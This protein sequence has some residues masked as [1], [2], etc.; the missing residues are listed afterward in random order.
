MLRKSFGYWLD[1]H[2][3]LRRSWRSPLSI[4]T[5]LTR[6]VAIAYIGAALLAAAPSDAWSQTPA[7]TRAEPIAFGALSAGNRFTCGLSTDGV[8]YCWGMD[9]LGQLGIGAIVG[10]C[11]ESIYAKGA[12]ARAPVAVFGGHRFLSISAGDQH[13]CAIDSAGDAYCWGENHFDQLG[14]SDVPDRCTYE[15]SRAG[16]SMSLACSRRPLRVPIGAPVVSIATGEHFTCAVDTSGRAWCWGGS[17]TPT[18][19]PL[20]RPLVSVAAGGNQVCGLTVDKGIRCWAWK[21]VLTDG[22]SA[23]SASTNWTALTVGAGHACALDTAGR[24]YCWGNDADGALGI[25]RNGH[26]KHLDVPMTPIVGDRR[27]RSIA[28]GATQTCGIDDSGALYCWGRVAAGLSDDQ[29][30]DSNG[31]AGTNDCMTHPLLVHRNHRFRA[32]AV[33]A[34]H[35]CS[36]STSGEALCWG[37]NEAGQ[38]GDGTLRATGELT[39]VRTRGISP[40]QARILDARERITWLLARGGFGLVVIIALMLTARDW[41]ASR[42]GR[43][44]LVYWIGALMFAAVLRASNSFATSR[45]LASLGAAAAIQLLVIVLGVTLYRLSPGLR[46]WWRAG[47]RTPA[48]EVGAPAATP[49]GQR[50]ARG[51]GALGGPVALAAVLLGWL[52]FAVSALSVAASDPRGEVA[53]GLAVLAL[54]Y[55]AGLTL[56]LSAVGAI[57]AILTLR[58]NRQARAAR[59]ALVL[60]SGTLVTGAV[61]AAMLFWP[62]ER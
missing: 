29:C 48:L 12:C 49:G 45:G 62:T 57:V 37:T 16:E 28:V 19:V 24:A 35:Q 1:R 11:A 7:T 13:A 60:A 20:D 58:R 10:R 34:R 26:D 54:L 5:R 18:V 51:V 44:L 38:L 42:S 3:L 43:D 2:Q 9:N 36:I 41:M 31:I 4:P 23:P 21:D 47:A 6:R 46:T 52:A 53:G 40:G 61:L 27:F 33:G 22:A 30:L 55:G 25:G 32:V 56:A 17:P 15:S 8:A 50:E 39:A 59:I 14:V